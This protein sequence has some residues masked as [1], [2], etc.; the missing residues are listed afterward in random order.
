MLTSG[1]QT[2]SPSLS[3]LCYNE[4]IMNKKRLVKKAIMAVTAVILAMTLYGCKA[5]PQPVNA[6]KDDSLQKVLDSKQLVIGLDDS[7]PPMG[8]RDETGEI[9]GFDIDVANEVCDRLGITLV[10][11]PIDWDKKEEELNSG[12]I[13]CIW[14]GMSV[15]PERA[16][17]MTLSEP[18]LKNTLIFVV[19]ERSDAKGLRDLKGKT[20][21]V[22]SGSTVVDA[23]KSSSIIGDI[24]VAEY[25]DNTKLVEELSRG[26]VDAILIDSIAAYYFIFSG[27]DKFYVLSDS[28]SEE[29][30]AIGFRKGDLS[31][32]DKIQEII[33][34]MKA[35]G[36][37]GKIS[38]KW[39]GTDI[40]I[41]R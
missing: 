4:V 28:I 36:S 25:D 21:G 31:L 17:A 13:D 15:T 30:C 1:P 11:Q 32:H 39:F 29:E 24:T 38:T 27:N 22:Q 37:L 12:A 16:E 9:V 8:F 35:D 19:T 33:S 23:L 40:T 7:Y 10:K 34:E 2:P 14:N 5:S 18:Y 26:K 20:I 6:V 3:P 41:V